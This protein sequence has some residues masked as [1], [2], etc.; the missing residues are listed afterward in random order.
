M[1]HLPQLQWDFRDQL[2]ATSMQRVNLGKTPITTYYVYDSSGQRVRKVTE[3]E[4]AD[5]ETP[6]R[7]KE[8]IYIALKFIVNIIK[9]NSSLNP[10]PWPLSIGVDIIPGLTALT[11]ILR[12]FKSTVHERA[13]DRTAALV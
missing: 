6:R 13:N 10:I 12:C 4:D 5:G 9:T 2:W 8:R 11:R 1:P 3:S 7:Q